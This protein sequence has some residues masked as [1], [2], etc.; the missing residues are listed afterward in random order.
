MKLIEYQELKGLRLD[1]NLSARTIICSVLTL[2]TPYFIMDVP[3]PVQFQKAFITKYI[4]VDISV[5]VFSQAHVGNSGNLILGINSVCDILGMQLV[6]QFENT[7]IESMYARLHMY[8]L[9]CKQA[10]NAIAT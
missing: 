7:G 4:C 9:A 10:R 3:Y 8:M 1:L 5:Y 6:V 2:C